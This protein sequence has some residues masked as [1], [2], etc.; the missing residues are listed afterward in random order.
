[1]IDLPEVLKV[2][3]NYIVVEIVTDREPG[4]AAKLD[5]R[6]K[7]YG[8]GANPLYVLQGPDGKVIDQQGGVQIFRDAF[9]EWLKK[10]LTGM[11]PSTPTP[12]KTA[13]A[14]ELHGFDNLA[15]AEA[16]AKKTG[17]PI[18]VDFTGEE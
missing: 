10:G 15:A 9:L 1:M 6:L 3:E 11:A 8:I 14:P 16:E 7:R 5:L 18:F 2:L 12:T 17:K 13:A 4:K